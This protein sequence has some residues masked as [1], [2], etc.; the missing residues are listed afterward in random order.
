M[1]GQDVARWLYELY[2]VCDGMSLPDV[3][4]GYFID[5]LQRVLNRDQPTDPQIVI[6]EKEIKV[7][8]IGS[9]GGG[10]HFVL[11]RHSGEVIFLPHGSLNAGRYDGRTV[12]V[13]TVA[14][15][16]SHSSVELLTRDVEAFCKGR[17][18]T[19]V[20]PRLTVPKPASTSALQSETLPTTRTATQRRNAGGGLSD[21]RDTG[22]VFICAAFTNKMFMRT[23]YPRLC[24]QSPFCPQSRDSAHK[25]HFG[26]P[27]TARRFCSQA[28]Q[29]G[30]CQF[31][32]A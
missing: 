15:S 8:P 31:R 6:L 24:L 21:S 26:R 5:P 22:D 27:P 4:F 14:H 1:F 25:S 20:Y 30:V 16:T 13:I 17:P 10:D 29:L 19:Q 18:I 2:S 9:T 23:L 12:R 7:L 11:D 28:M 32:Q 3:H